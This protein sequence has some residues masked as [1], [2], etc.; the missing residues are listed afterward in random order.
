M[1]LEW[2]CIVKSGNLLKSPPPESMNK[3]R[4]KTRYFVLYNPNLN[5]SNNR[6]YRN[7]ARYSSGSDTE[8]PQPPPKLPPRN[9][10]HR[11][12]S[13]AE[14]VLRRFRSDS[15]NNTSFDGSEFKT[16]MLFIFDDSEKEMEGM[17]PRSK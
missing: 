10:R 17:P 15:T 9:K 3:K 12:S 16:P 13:I 1:P 4:W 5:K 11:K 7:S 8:T 6:K 14:N 2:K